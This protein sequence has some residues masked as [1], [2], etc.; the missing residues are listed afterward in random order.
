M[1]KLPDIEW[2]THVVV[3][4]SFWHMSHAQTLHTNI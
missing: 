1:I 3:S 2:N 4:I